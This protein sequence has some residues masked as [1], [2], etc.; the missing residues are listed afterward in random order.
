MKTNLISRSLLCTG[1]LCVAIVFVIS[2]CS[3]SSGG[4]NAADSSRE[5]DESFEKQKKTTEGLDKILQAVTQVPAKEQLSAAP[6]RDALGFFILERQ[7]GEAFKFV[8]SPQPNSSTG[9]Y[10]PLNTMRVALVTY[11]KVDDGPYKIVEKNTT[12]PGF[13]L[14]AEVVLIDHSIPAV[15]HRKT[16]RGAKP[17]TMSPNSNYS[18][19]KAGDTEVVGKKPIDEIQKFLNALP[20][21][22]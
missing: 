7:K 17:E 5:L 6:E 4:I 11:N 22:K 10:A 2:G 8:N 20:Y 3:R 18:T 15:V 1:V 21:K 9:E 16:F 19:I 13:R 12:I 14:D